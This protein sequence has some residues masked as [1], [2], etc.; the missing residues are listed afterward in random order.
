MALRAVVISGALSA[1]P[2]PSGAAN[3]APVGKAATADPL[4]ASISEASRMFGLPASWIGAVMQIESGRQSAATSSAGAMGLM[5]LMPSTYA[6][7]RL[8]LGLGPDAYDTHDNII[9]GAAYLRD[10]F[11]RYGPAGF[12]AAYNAGPGRWE[13]HRDGHKSLPSETVQYIGKVIARIRQVDPHMLERAPTTEAKSP[14]RSPIFVV[15]N[16]QI[17][18]P[19]EHTADDR[20]AADQRLGRQ[21]VTSSSGPLSSVP[22]RTVRRSGTQAASLRDNALHRSASADGKGAQPADPLFIPRTLPREVSR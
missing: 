16:A 3:S 1:F 12:L 6:A 11:D 9:A 4:A 17:G 14:V 10:M 8:R 13:A 20:T 5:Q 19:D 22:Q 15:A 2:L 7:L 21:A 18:T